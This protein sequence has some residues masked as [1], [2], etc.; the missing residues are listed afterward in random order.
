MGLFPEAEGIG[1]GPADVGI[2][3]DAELLEDERGGW[4]VGTG[5]GERDGDD[6]S[7]FGPAAG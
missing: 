2:G 7:G 4:G 3:I 1:G 6:F 5:D